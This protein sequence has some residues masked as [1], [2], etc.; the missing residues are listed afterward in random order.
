MVT[1]RAPKGQAFI[2]YALILILVVMAVI[3]ILSVLGPS[4]GSAY[5]QVISAI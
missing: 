4:I 2:E 1:F 3:V 5:S